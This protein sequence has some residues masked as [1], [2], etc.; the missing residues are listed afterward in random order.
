MFDVFFNNF[1]NNYLWISADVT[2]DTLGRFVVNVIVGILHPIIP[3]KPYV[4]IEC[5]ISDK[6]NAE[7][8][9]SIVDDC[10]NCTYD[11]A[12]EKYKKVLVF[13]SDA[14]P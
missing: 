12:D 11:N 7:I 8:I 14:V 1:G 2:I 9:S 3:Y 13:V 5:N 10:L 6:V 4:V